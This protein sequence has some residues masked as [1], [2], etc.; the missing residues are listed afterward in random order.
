MLCKRYSGISDMSDEVLIKVEKVFQNF[1]IEEGTI[2]IIKDVSFEVRSNS[3]NIIYGAS[4]SGKSTLLNILSGLQTPS[5]GRVLFKGQDVYAFSPDELAHFR[6]NQIGIVYQ[7]NYWVQSLNVLENV[8]IP[9]YFLGYTRSSAMQKALS[10]LEKIDMQ[11]YAKKY[12]IL[13]SGGEQQRVA[14]A[15]AIVNDP[16]FIIADEPTGSLDSKNGD[17]VMDLLR[18]AHSDTKRTII[19]VT[20]NMEYL[21]LADNLLHIQDGVVQNPDSQSVQTISSEMITS[22]KQRL[23]KFAAAKEEEQ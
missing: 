14:V 19:L 7:S 13:L 8:A 20:H 18:S 16:M 6:A 3:F 10:A 22:L 1:A 15:R 11:S 5:K 17:K 4:G 23:D 9:L 12:P 2:E 21:P